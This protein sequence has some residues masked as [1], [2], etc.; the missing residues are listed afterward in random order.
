MTLLHKAFEDKKFDVRLVE[1]NI[2]RGFV[3]VD[4]VQQNLGELPD[5]AENADYISLDVL[6]NEGA[7]VCPSEQTS[8]LDP[9]QTHH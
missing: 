3:S 4:D 8:T 7:E 6:L 2:S 1:K 9:V 5:D